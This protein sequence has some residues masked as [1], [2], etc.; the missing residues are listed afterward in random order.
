MLCRLLVK[1]KKNKAYTDTIL[2]GNKY[3]KTRDTFSEHIPRS[4]IDYYTHLG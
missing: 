2:L 1:N 3:K 4:L